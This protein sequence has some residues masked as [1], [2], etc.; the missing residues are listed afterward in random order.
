VADCFR[1]ADKPV[2]TRR[3]RQPGVFIAKTNQQ[4]QAKLREEFPR[5]PPVERLQVFRHASPNPGCLAQVVAGEERLRM[6]H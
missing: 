5:N 6:R 3:N 4:P 2:T 1:V